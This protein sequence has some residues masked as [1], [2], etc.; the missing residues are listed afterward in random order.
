LAPS[1]AVSW[2]RKGA[3]GGA[4]AGGASGGEDR[5]ICRCATVC[6]AVGR[7]RAAAARTGAGA[8]AVA[9]KGG[10]ARTA[11]RTERARTVARDPRGAGPAP[12]SPCASGTGMRGRRAA[13]AGPGERAEGKGALVAERALCRRAGGPGR[14]VGASGRGMR[15][16]GAVCGHGIGC[17]GAVPRRPFPGRGVC[18]GVRQVAPLALFRCAHGPGGLSRVGAGGS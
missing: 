6:A 17:C 11:Q 8:R 7:A 16:S 4:A 15:P 12:R 10:R 13:S 14:G 2:Q 9:A 5:R 18:G 3:R 1:A